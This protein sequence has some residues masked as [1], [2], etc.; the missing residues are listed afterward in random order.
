MGTQRQVGQD[1]E[2]STATDGIGWLDKA[3][4][5]G[6]LAAAMLGLRAMGL[7]QLTADTSLCPLSSAIGFSMDVTPPA[8][9]TPRS[10]L[11]SVHQHLPH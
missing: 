1:G 5:E 3:Q 7:L 8:E 11:K 9:I 10:A 6:L 2:I 4:G